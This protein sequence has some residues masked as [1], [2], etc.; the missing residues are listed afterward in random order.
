[1]SACRLVSI[2]WFLGSALR[3]QSAYGLDYSV[4]CSGVA[5]DAEID[6]AIAQTTTGP[7]RLVLSSG[8][9]LIEAAHPLNGSITLDVVGAG[10]AS[11]ILHG[12]GIAIPM[13]RV[14]QTTGGVA[15]GLHSLTLQHAPLGAITVLNSALRV[16]SVQF[17]D[18]KAA[19]V[20]SADF[21]TVEI[22]NSR[23]VGNVGDGGTIRMGGGPWGRLTIVNTA[24]AGNVTDQNGGAINANVPVD[25]DRVLFVGNTANNGYGGAIYMIETGLSIRNSTFSGNSAMYGGAIADNANYESPGT[26]LRNVTL[27]GDV[28]SSSGSEIYIGGS[29]PPP[30]SIFNSLVAGTCA[31]PVIVTT[32]HGSVE[33]PGDTCGISGAGN[34]VDVTEEALHLG[35]L[36][37]NG[38]ATLTLYPNP[39]SVLIDAASI[40]CETVDQRE[41]VRD[42]GA[43][44]VG[45]VEAGATLADKIFAD[46]FGN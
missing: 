17:S 45:A 35:A 26:T 18:N 10:M 39:G 7:V 27:H 15:L 38:G 20:I 3:F 37:D 24:F 9:C 31:G 2:A 25:L 46:V 8:T 34:Q 5:I 19:T 4:E 44:D 43:C 6:A 12:Q 11:T 30:I 40:D 28:G 16:D 23:F 32:A 1:M 36:A 14:G 33:S 41:L 29:N 22:S 21:S 42:V 13:F